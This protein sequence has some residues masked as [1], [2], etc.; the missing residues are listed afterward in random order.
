MLPLLSDAELRP[1]GTGGHPKHHYWAPILHPTCWVA[2]R[3]PNAAGCA[4]QQLHPTAAL[5]ALTLQ[6]SRQS[7]PL[8]MIS[9]NLVPGPGI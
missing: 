7:G 4:L 5:P 3:P 8:Q 2:D 1:A 6:A 9:D